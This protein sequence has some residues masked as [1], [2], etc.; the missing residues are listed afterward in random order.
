MEYDFKWHILHRLL[1]LD[2]LCFDSYLFLPSAA[3][4]N[5]GIWQV[6]A[7]SSNTLNN[8]IAQRTSKCVHFEY[9]VLRAAIWRRKTVSLLGGFLATNSVQEL[10][11]RTVIIQRKDPAY[12]LD[13]FSKWVICHQKYIFDGKLRPSN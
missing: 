13:L 12:V 8:T 4:H 1:L 10:I 9:I 7:F 2:L 11:L 5:R 3:A 6:K